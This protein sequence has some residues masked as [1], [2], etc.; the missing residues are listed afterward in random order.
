M[1]QWKMVAWVHVRIIYL[2]SPGRT[3]QKSQLGQGSAL[4]SVLLKKNLGLGTYVVAWTFTTY[5][6][7]ILD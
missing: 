1:D 2:I 6:N 4:C 7:N 5:L 3:M